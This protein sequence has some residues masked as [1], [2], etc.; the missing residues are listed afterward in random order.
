MKQEPCLQWRTASYDVDKVDD[1]IEGQV[2]GAIGDAFVDVLDHI[3]AFL[4]SDDRTVVRSS[5]YDADGDSI[6]GTSDHL[7]FP[8]GSRRH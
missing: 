2:D 3:V 5:L 1:T 8:L 4:G 6:V 7:G